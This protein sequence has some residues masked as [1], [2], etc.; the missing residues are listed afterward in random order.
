VFDYAIDI[1]GD[2][3]RGRGGPA[4]SV[5]LSGKVGMVVHYNGPPVGESR[6][7]REFLRSVADYHVAR[8]WSSRP[9]VTPLIRGDG[10]MYHLAVGRRGDVYQ[11]RDLG[12]VLWHCGS[13]PENETYLSV[14]VILG[15]EQ[16]ATPLQ[17]TALLN[18]ADEWTG[19]AG[20]R[21]RERVIG[22]QEVDATT[23]PGTLMDDFVL[24]YRGVSMTCDGRFFAETGYYV[25]GPFW[26]YW[27]DNGGLMIFGLPLTNELEEDGR[28]VQY[29]ERCVMEWHPE[30]PAGFRVLLRLLGA[31]ALRAA[32]A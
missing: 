19:S 15:G 32:R 12:S 5:P 24:P 11:L 9:G 29:F 27:R 17:L 26:Q 28:T 13:W 3:A 18:L 8:D 23:C 31:Q 16:R 2:L 20:E 25:G 1:R 10:I 14:L 21:T 6:N 4:W 22:H 7:E 30:N